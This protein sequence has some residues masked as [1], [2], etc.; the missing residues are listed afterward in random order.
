MRQFSCRTAVKPSAHGYFPFVLS[1]KLTLPIST[2]RYNRFTS[3]A[4]E[5]A[6]VKPQPRLL[7]G[8][9]HLIYNW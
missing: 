4:G 2:L 1:I 6:A 5:N 3:K 9:H 8:G 7:V